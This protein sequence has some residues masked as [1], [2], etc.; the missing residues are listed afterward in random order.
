MLPDPTISRARPVLH[1]AFRQ[2]TAPTLIAS[3]IAGGGRSK[4]CGESIDAEQAGHKNPVDIENRYRPKTASRGTKAVCG[5]RADEKF[6]E[7]E[8]AHAEAY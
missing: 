8:I 2:D 6:L 1:A 4:C 3:L 7:A 5:M